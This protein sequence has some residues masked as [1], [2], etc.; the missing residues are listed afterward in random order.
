MLLI[1]FSASVE[2]LVLIVQKRDLEDRYLQSLRHR[3]SST[4]LCILESA[5]QE[6]MERQCRHSPAPAAFIL[7]AAGFS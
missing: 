7:I 6:V 2:F 1:Y 5:R 3:G 4:G